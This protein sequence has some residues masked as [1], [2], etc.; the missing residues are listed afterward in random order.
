M[1]LIFGIFTWI[2]E[3]SHAMK[4]GHFSEVDVSV[5]THESDT[6]T[7]WILPES[8]YVSDTLEYF[9]LINFN[10]FILD[11]SGYSRDPY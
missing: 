1:Y 6:D 2:S 3:L 10:L 7:L 4:L 11:S 5:S 9:N 8:G